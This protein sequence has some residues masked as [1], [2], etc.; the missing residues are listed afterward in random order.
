[1]A[2]YFFDVHFDHAVRRDCD[3]LELANL[4]QA[5]AEANHARTEIMAEDKL[6]HLKIEI[7]DQEGRVVATVG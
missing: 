5:I 4:D 7:I 6:R 1:M 3:G 2:R